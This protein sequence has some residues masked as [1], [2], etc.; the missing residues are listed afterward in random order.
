MYF[1]K[2]MFKITLCFLFIYFTVARTS[3][4]EHD[5][6]AF[7]KLQHSLIFDINPVWTERGNISIQSLRLGQAIVNQK[8]LT[9]EVQKKLQ[10]LA[11]RNS[12]YQIKSTVTDNDGSERSFIS[13]VKAC[14][15]AE[16]ELD[17]RL[18]VSLDYMGR[19]IGVSLIV[20][21]KSTCEG[22]IVP[23]EKLKTFSTSV[24]VR[25]SETGPIPDT[26]T[27]IQ[28]LEREREAKEKGE[29]KDNRS[30]LAKY[31]MYIVPLLIFMAISSAANP[32]ST[33]TQ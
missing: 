15:L 28:K 26:A 2:K 27:F 17:D 3:N 9:L 25:H 24:Y 11:A 13:T 14:M 10:D 20:A 31:W 32:D 29:G 5:G 1:H 8:P 33:Q 21:S 4:L 30:F 22:A 16:S 23:L 6:S 12:F 18:S 19:I 7:I